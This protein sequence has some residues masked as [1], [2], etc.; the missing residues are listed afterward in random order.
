MR[1]GGDGQWNMVMTEFSMTDLVGQEIRVGDQWAAV[2]SVE[3]KNNFVDGKD[4]SSWTLTLSTPLSLGGGMALT[5][6]EMNGSF[7]TVKQ[8][9]FATHGLPMGGGLTVLS[10]NG[11]PVLFEIDGGG[12]HASPNQKVTVQGQWA[13]IEKTFV[14]TEVGALRIGKSVAEAQGWLTGENFQASATV[15]EKGE[16]ILTRRT[17]AMPIE[18]RN[19]TGGYD[20]V[21]LDSVGGLSGQGGLTVT[22]QGLGLAAGS[23]VHTERLEINL[24]VSE[25]K[26]GSPTRVASVSTL[27]EIK[28]DLGYV[29]G[30]VEFDGQRFNINSAGAQLTVTKGLT[31]A[32]KTVTRDAIFRF[33][34]D[35]RTTLA[36]DGQYSFT[37]E[38]AKVTVDGKAPAVRADGVVYS[39]E[40]KIEGNTTSGLKERLATERDTHEGFSATVVLK[41]S[42]QHVPVY[43][44]SRDAESLP[45]WVPGGD[46]GNADA[47]IGSV[48]QAG[49]A[50]ETMGGGATRG[51][52]VTVLGTSGEGKSSTGGP[53]PVFSVD[54]MRGDG[55]RVQL[56]GDFSRT[57]SLSGWAGKD[58]K[59][60]E[61]I[62]LGKKL[63]SSVAQGINAQRTEL[64]LSPVRGLT[65]IG[66]SGELVIQ[67]T[68]KTD[69]VSDTHSVTVKGKSLQGYSFAVFTEQ[70]VLRAGGSGGKAYPVNGVNEVLAENGS[71]G[72]TVS[73]QGIQFDGDRLVLVG[74]GTLGRFTAVAEGK[75]IQTQWTGLNGKMV[76]MSI[77][78]L[79][80]KSV[81][82]FK[83]RLDVRL[84][85]K[86]NNSNTY[87]ITAR[88][89]KGGMRDV[90]DVRR[91]EAG[92]GSYSF[93]V[94]KLS[95][96]TRSDSVLR[97]NAQIVIR[98]LGMVTAQTNGVGAVFGKDGQAA[99]YGQWQGGKLKLTYSLTDRVFRDFKTG[100]VL[101]R[102]ATVSDGKKT[103][104]YAVLTSGVN[105]R[106][107]QFAMAL[108]AGFATTSTV[109]INKNGVVVGKAGARAFVASTKGLMSLQAGKDG[110]FR[111]TIREGIEESEKSKG[112]MVLARID[113]V[114][115]TKGLVNQR[116]E[117]KLSGETAFKTD[118]VRGTIA[119][120]GGKYVV[121][122]SEIR[123]GGKWVGVTDQGSVGGNSLVGGKDGKVYQSS[124]N[125]WVAVQ[126]VTVETPYS[127]G[128]TEL[129]KTIAVGVTAGK[130][131]FTDVGNGFN[132]PE[133]TLTSRVLQA[134]HKDGVK[135]DVAF[136]KGKWDA[137]GLSSNQ[138]SNV[139]VSGKEAVLVVDGEGKAQLLNRQGGTLSVNIKS[140]D[141]TGEMRDRSLT[142]LGAKW[143]GDRMG[144][145]VVGVSESVKGDRILVPLGT[146]KGDPLPANAKT[147]GYKL[148]A[149]D[150]K[151]G[152]IF[153]AVQDRARMTVVLPMENKTTFD[154]NELSWIPFTAGSEIDVLAMGVAYG[155]K[156]MGNIHLSIGD[157]GAFSVR[158]LGGEKHGVPTARFGGHVLPAGTEVNVGADGSVRAVMSGGD[159][160]AFVAFLESHGVVTS[161]GGLKSGVEFLGTVVANLQKTGALPLGNSATFHVDL[162]NGNVGMAMRGGSLVEVLAGSENKMALVKSGGK[163]LGYES[164]EGMLMNSLA[165]AGADIAIA[166]VT[167]LTSDWAIKEIRTDDG[168]LRLTD[169]KD[170]QGRL[171]NGRFMESGIRE[172]ADKIRAG[173]GGFYVDFKMGGEDSLSRQYISWNMGSGNFE[174]FEMNERGALAEYA[175]SEKGISTKAGEN[176]SLVFM[177]R[178]VEVDTLSDKSMSSVTVNM[179]DGKL[180]SLMRSSRELSVG[181]AEIVKALGSM[182]YLTTENWSRGGEDVLRNQYYTS[183]DGSI[184][185][186][187]ARPQWENGG[188]IGQVVLTTSLADGR[189]ETRYFNSFGGGSVEGNGAKQV[190]TLS[191]GKD[192][193]TAGWKLDKREVVSENGRIQT[194]VRNGNPIEMGED[195]MQS[196]LSYSNDSNKITIESGETIYLNGNK[197][198]NDS[199]AVGAIFV[200][201]LGS[202]FEGTVAFGGVSVQRT[203]GAGTTW[204][205]ISDWA[206]PQNV[207]Y[208]AG[209]AVVA[210]ATIVVSFPLA[211]GAAGFAALAAGEAIGSISLSGGTIFGISM[212]ALSHGFGAFQVAAGIAEGDIGKVVVG[213]VLGFLPGFVVSGA[214]GKVVNWVAGE[215]VGKA[216][217]RLGSTPSALRLA[218]LADEGSLGAKLLT[219]G[220]AH[221]AKNSKVLANFG[222]HNGTDLASFV[223]KTVEE[224][225]PFMAKYG[226][227]SNKM[228][229]SS[230]SMGRQVFRMAEWAV[231]PLSR[232]ASHVAGDMMAKTFASTSNMAFRSGQMVFGK[233]PMLALSIAKNVVMYGAPGIVPFIETPMGFVPRALGMGESASAILGLLVWSPLLRFGMQSSAGQPKAFISQENWSA[234]KAFM[235]RMTSNPGPTLMQ[236]VLFTTQAR[237]AF[238]SLLALKKGDLTLKIFGGMGGVLKTV[239]VELL[240]IIPRT[241][242]ILSDVAKFNLI[243]ASVG[244]TINTALGGDPIMLFGGLVQIPVFSGATT[245]DMFANAIHQLAGEAVRS[246]TDIKML[247]FALMLAFVGP[248]VGPLLRNLPVLGPAMQY[249]GKFDA[250]FGSFGKR[251]QGFMWEEGVQEK[252]PEM[253][254]ARIGLSHEQSEVFQELFDKR[255]GLAA[256]STSPMV[257]QRWVNGG[258]QANAVQ[259]ATHQTSAA[260]QVVEKA[261]IALMSGVEL[262]GQAAQGHVIAPVGLN[263]LNSIGNDNY[264]SDDYDPA[265]DR[266]NYLDSA[267]VVLAGATEVVRS[268]LELSGLSDGASLISFVGEHAVALAEH[269]GIEALTLYTHHALRAEGYNVR[270]SA[271]FENI[272]E[273][274][275]PPVAAVGR[276][277]TDRAVRSLSLLGADILT[278][279]VERGMAYNDQ[280]AWGSRLAAQIGSDTRTLNSSAISAETLQDLEGFSGSVGDSNSRVLL[281]AWGSAMTG[282]ADLLARSVSQGGVG[283]TSLTSIL[284]SHYQERR[285]AAV[286]SEGVAAVRAQMMGD[287]RAV[288]QM[289][290]AIGNLAGEAG[291]QRLMDRNWAELG[292]LV[293][294]STDELP[295]VLE[296]QLFS[297]LTPQA[298]RLVEK[299]VSPQMG[300]ILSF[301]V[302]PW[303]ALLSLGGSFVHKEINEVLGNF[304]IS[305]DQFQ[306]ANA[307]RQLAK[308]GEAKDWKS[309][310]KKMTMGKPADAVPLTVGMVRAAAQEGAGRNQVRVRELEQAILGIL[311]ASTPSLGAY[312]GTIL[313]L[314]PSTKI[315][316][317]VSVASQVSAEKLE[318][319]L[320]ER[321]VRYAQKNAAV[322]QEPLTLSALSVAY[323]GLQARDQFRTSYF[324]AIH[325]A[326][327]SRALEM[328]ESTFASD[329]VLPRISNRSGTNQMNF[330]PLSTE[331]KG[332]FESF[333]EAHVSEGKEFFTR[334][335]GADVRK[336]VRAQV[337]KEKVTV[338]ALIVAYDVV[339]QGVAHRDYVNSSLPEK[340]PMA[341]SVAES[342][343][344]EL[345]RED[346]VP[347]LHQEFSGNVNVIIPAGLSRS[348]N[349]EMTAKKEPAL[350]AEQ[351]VTIR[352]NT[353]YPV[354]IHDLGSLEI[355]EIESAWSSVNAGVAWPLASEGMG[356]A[357]FE[358]NTQ[359][360][361]ERGDDQDAE[362]R[363]AK[364]DALI[365][366]SNKAV[367]DRP[368]T[369]E[370]LLTHEKKLKVIGS[371]IVQIM[372]PLITS[373]LVDDVG[374]LAVLNRS[375][376]KINKAMK[377]IRTRLDNGDVLSPSDSQQENDLRF[378]EGKSLPGI[379]FDTIQEFVMIS[380]E[381]EG[382]RSVSFSKISEF[383]KDPETEKGV[384]SRDENVPQTSKATVGNSLDIAALDVGGQRTAG[385]VSAGVALAGMVG[386]ALAGTVLAMVPL[387]I[388]GVAGALS[389]SYFFTN[390]RR[391]V[392]QDVVLPGSPTAWV[393]TTDQSIQ[394]AW[395][396]FAGLMG[397][398]WMGWANPLGAW[399]RNSL[400]AATLWHEQTHRI[401]G[402][403]ELGAALAQVM[404]T[405]VSFAYAGARTVGQVFRGK[406]GQVEL[407]LV[408]GSETGE[409]MEALEQGL[410]EEQMTENVQGLIRQAKES[411]HE[412]MG[413]VI[414]RVEPSGL[415]LQ[416]ILP[417]PQ[418]AVQN[419]SAGQVVVDPRGLPSVQS[420]GSWIPTHVHEDQNVLRDGRGMP[421]PSVMDLLSPAGNHQGLVLDTNGNMTLYKLAR[422]S[423]GIAVQM[424]SKAMGDGA[425]GKPVTVPLA[426]WILEAVKRGEAVPLN[427]NNGPLLVGLVQAAME[428][429]GLIDEGSS[430]L[431]LDQLVEL[432][433]R[434][435]QAVGDRV[436]PQNF[437]IATGVVVAHFNAVSEGARPYV[438]NLTEIERVNV[439]VQKVLEA[440]GLSPF[441]HV[442]R[443]QLVVES[444]DSL[445]VVGET[446]R[447]VQLDGKPLTASQLTEGA[448]SDRIKA[449]EAV[450][451]QVMNPAY[452]KLLG[453]G[454]ERPVQ[455]GFRTA[456][457]GLSEARMTG[458]GADRKYQVL[459]DGKASAADV[460]AQLAH[461]MAEVHI[462]AKMASLSPLKGSDRGDIEALSL[463]LSQQAMERQGLGSL[464]RFGQSLFLKDV[465]AGENLLREDARRLAFRLVGQVQNLAGT[466]RNRAESLFAQ[467]FERAGRGI[468]LLEMA[469]PL[470]FP[471]VLTVD[472]ASLFTEGRFNGD[473]WKDLMGQVVG[474]DSP[475]KFLLVADNLT[476]E[477]QRAELAKRVQAVRGAKMAPKSP[478]G[479]A[480]SLRRLQKALPQL[481]N[482]D[483][484][485]IPMVHMAVVTTNGDIWTDLNGLV[486]MIL[487]GNVQETITNAIKAS[488]VVNLSA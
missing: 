157:G 3:G 57:N 169:K 137:V 480:V 180:V 437:R 375:L 94:G 136:T 232:G 253:L 478:L 174:R 10:E 472:G 164:K 134:T 479:T 350:L 16:V 457:E 146:G 21:S 279:G 251:Y 249:L 385:L 307:V 204:D 340:S 276:P 423:Y 293:T 197:Y 43:W 7:H 40:T 66:R 430:R 377:L 1:Q 102:M 301:A 147:E 212:L 320:G 206:T 91:V 386:A 344:G 161:V 399:N 61:I 438:G 294:A 130:L 71:R 107:V 261:D 191:W 455:I 311:V 29:S 474:A 41:N 315:G 156:E 402:A 361:V 419:A 129:T 422:T 255:P 149:K 144:V 404:P 329:V 282:Q 258:F 355:A 431:T 390:W 95:G 326:V 263:V 488:W 115:T 213:G 8:M 222:I 312:A 459:L 82:E 2:K 481:F 54:G 226:L 363:S 113:A 200:E 131:T 173:S 126:R 339:A 64:G 55:T 97:G 208:A 429:E 142:V 240:Q 80:G 60:L 373:D 158:S 12:L 319:L 269:V 248:L 17:E 475:E 50:M 109:T 90:A 467:V 245:I 234:T 296:S 414:Y 354:M 426:Q 358:P 298:N 166:K 310:V 68:G 27:L 170:T 446:L 335:L 122:Y 224:I 195:W 464:A 106:L 485:Y 143:N 266:L 454:M 418:S 207:A 371:E 439:G 163:V 32:Q 178:N 295:R 247:E 119:L 451:N 74:E 13:G 285:V 172:Y 216:A 46:L 211:M 252:L 374:D 476:D 79:S 394:V 274:I 440:W 210:V 250:F 108:G 332:E 449:L 83:S 28:G 444:V 254:A 243:M 278:N 321:T 407:K 214:F 20:K 67:T 179:G 101:G 192:G 408:S 104:Q 364:I 303:F 483:V 33:G 155:G 152:N 121:R 87:S 257:S 357:N 73:I 188:T 177:V 45:L 351:A 14:A 486:P 384:N 69:G 411:G 151:G 31:Y 345:V 396:R 230:T 132:V 153:E 403:N 47:L 353:G 84:T 35:G 124:Q 190:D 436:T 171:E 38:G 52:S 316:E 23:L 458:E 305:H 85:G 165:W 145:D 356:L 111:L 272:I 228:W 18:V 287:L 42:S 443:D 127:I 309:M 365:D 125:G 382:V 447:G 336:E 448:L 338:T 420:V 376:G 75:R 34:D 88:D 435:A 378:D 65:I 450:M 442:T 100:K 275:A 477:N 413:Q 110:I 369:K 98:E 44:S 470:V 36:N 244:G 463:A 133:G 237:S 229:V 322:V 461:E 103:V 314:D 331:A 242:T 231:N 324:E 203:T 297:G 277:I 325:Q 194:V 58:G 186:S 410:S 138:K 11:G 140:L 453:Y 360:Q 77:Y 150:D 219:Q 184:S 99:G 114:L 70:K 215:W 30:T 39:T 346:R 168:V 482:W 62:H 381:T 135:V 424:T 209:A 116:H 299:L 53:V 313:S 415:K 19:S 341:R 198:T 89:R 281:N 56:T 24:K 366:K 469:G 81:G 367:S 218:G 433:R 59:I 308:G 462:Y 235:G 302:S 185:G 460:L 387:V 202:R 343:G 159:Q 117:T 456:G 220:V 6:V 268:D 348:V 139:V 25:G 260:S 201:G 290:T 259:E 92:N 270:N 256:R 452:Q 383:A 292:R 359:S 238:Q 468:S 160:K 96:A 466:D 273:A 217:L 141:E 330:G 347:L 342:M 471:T 392:G 154:K 223:G 181:N 118:S 441:L 26:E 333:L 428:E 105:G 323:Q 388:V 15:S 262:A 401:Y 241:V 473:L 76:E 352:Q 187:Y 421:I 286:G 484:S 112:V 239:G 86:G 317:L 246:L 196:G 372:L 280:R 233:V 123:S 72:Q 267:A 406:W 167:D 225:A 445:A 370:D 417:A 398:G 427:G 405:F 189:R 416:G 362:D 306:A 487:K 334:L 389:S 379:P 120:E 412:V 434:L 432:E 4:L 393:D 148:V 400:A 284:L 289:V 327:P 227:E 409:M 162:T 291:V 182:G 283:L 37:F 175:N 395:G 318:G 300:G 236:E 288:D 205:K 183:S 49:A 199:G 48:Q 22:A 51:L 328:D 380:G 271:G 397:T 128:K 304:A 425:F 176:G 265:I 9:G 349:M 93:F 368:M 78:S 5:A 193:D 63:D 264:L 221:G 337:G 465:L 391:E